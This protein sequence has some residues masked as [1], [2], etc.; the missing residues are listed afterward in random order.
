MWFAM[1]VCNVVIPWAILWN[2]KWRSTPWLVG[3]VGIAINVG[4]WFERYIIVPI[5]VTINRMPFTW[6][7]YKPGI[8]VPM[9]IGTVAL[10]ILLYMVASKLIPLIPVWEVEEGQMAHELK[11]FGRETVVAVSELE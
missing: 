10:F 2:T 7:L 1:L 5:S 8:E 3:F 6:R 9:G 4:M 11:K